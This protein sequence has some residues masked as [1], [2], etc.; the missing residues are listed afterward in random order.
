[1]AAFKKTI[2]IVLIIVLVV[3]MTFFVK[4]KPADAFI[5]CILDAIGLLA[6]LDSAVNKVFSVLPRD[7]VIQTANP[8]KTVPDIGANLKECLL[9]Q[10]AF[11]MANALIRNI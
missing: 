7:I 2:V 9:D 6:G 1:M 5:S 11:T 10:I 8:Q 3:P 4:P